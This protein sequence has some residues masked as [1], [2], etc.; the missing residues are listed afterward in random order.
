MLKILLQSIAEI[1]SCS[2]NIF[3]KIF[4]SF[5]S[6]YNF[7]YFK[8]PLTCR[9]LGRVRTLFL[10][11]SYLQQIV[12]PFSTSLKFGSLMLALPHTFLHKFSEEGLT[13]VSQFL[14]HVLIPPDITIIYAIK[15]WN[16][17]GIVVRRQFISAALS[18]W[19]PLQ[20]N[21]V[22]SCPLDFKPLP[23]PVQAKRS[24]VPFGKVVV[25]SSGRNSFILLPV[26]TRTTG[27]SSVL[28]SS[29]SSLLWQVCSY[30]AACRQLMVQHRA[31][32]K[33]LTSC[34]KTSAIVSQGI[35]PKPNENA[36]TY[37]QKQKTGI[38][39]T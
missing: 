9:S 22:V 23:S 36:P 14:G 37:E 39:E 34:E 21:V 28:R 5:T 29:D 6:S 4:K 2:P 10:K 12:K 26:F 1:I 15:Q 38:H 8:R 30:L 3:L 19:L 17:I 35:G 18:N 16:N 7:Q 11:S 31:T 33:P 20:D 27:A 24:S 32:V 25:F 13:F